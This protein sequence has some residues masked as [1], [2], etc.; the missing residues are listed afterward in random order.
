MSVVYMCVFVYVC[1]YYECDV[2]VYVS[3][4][5]CL[6]VLLCIRP[7]IMC[8]LV[9]HS[10]ELCPLAINTLILVLGFCYFMLTNDSYVSLVA[11]HD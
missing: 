7:M 6:C 1:V 5:V 4:C 9:M 10:T 8:I 2:Y 3:V 11:F